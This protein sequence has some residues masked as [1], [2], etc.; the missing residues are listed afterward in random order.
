MSFIAKN[1]LKIPEIETTPPLPLP[2]MRG[3]FAKKDGWYEIDSNGVVKKLAPIEE[4]INE[5]NDLKEKVELLCAKSLVKTATIILSA[6][7]WATDSDNQ[8]S[9]V[10]AIEGITQYSKID[11]QPTPEQLTIFHE[12]DIAFVTENDGGVVTVY[13]IGQKPVN[14]YEIQT[15]ITE[16][17]I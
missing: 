14:D 7:A 8:Y 10:I 15:T 11:L 2:G 5:L 3:L 16:V 13:C 17:E 12:K 4:L 9:Q 1:P 6:S